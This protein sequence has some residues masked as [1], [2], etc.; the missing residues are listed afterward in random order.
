[1]DRG[2][3]V[4]CPLLPATAMSKFKNSNVVRLTFSREYDLFRILEGFWIPGIFRMGPCLLT[5]HQ[6]LSP[7]CPTDMVV[8]QVAYALIT[9]LLEMALEPVYCKYRNLNDL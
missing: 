3:A 9:E 4:R 7:C 1:M 6:L 2:Q 8:F 5:D